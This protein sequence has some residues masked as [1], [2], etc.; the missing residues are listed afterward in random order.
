MK[1]SHSKK[2]L[3]KKQI[4]KE[5]KKI[6]NALAKQATKKSPN[7]PSIVKKK[8]VI[9]SGIQINIDEYIEFLPENLVS[10]L[11]NKGVCNA[12]MCLAHI[13]DSER[14]TNPKDKFTSLKSSSCKELIC[15]GYYLCSE[16][17]P[18]IIL[19]V[20]YSGQQHYLILYLPYSIRPIVL[21]RHISQKKYGEMI[22]VD[23]RAKIPCVPY[24]YD[25]AY[26]Y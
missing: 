5:A 14:S 1:G 25:G 11:K 22:K 15:V 3:T 6:K 21:K 19:S 20:S 10:F 13:G 24:F 23:S 4:E 2:Q 8:N 7:S 17:N 9:H 26:N 12:R 18:G 16:K